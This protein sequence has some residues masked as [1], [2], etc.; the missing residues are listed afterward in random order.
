MSA[1]DQVDVERT[2]E[3][4]LEQLAHTAVL[5]AQAEAESKE[6]AA[7]HDRAIERIDKRLDRAVRLG[8]RE[9]RNERQR[10]QEM[11]GRWDEKM[12]QLA[13]AQLVTEEKLQ[14][15][16]VKLEDLGGKLAGLIDALR[17]GGNGSH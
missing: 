17:R 7:R 15:L 6:R 4:I 9:L 1:G 16:D 5:Q 11:D 12:T 8:V 14:I 2:I 13:A 10:R 3:I